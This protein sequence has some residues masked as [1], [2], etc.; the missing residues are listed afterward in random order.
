MPAS[1][2]SGTVISPLLIPAVSITDE[3]AYKYRGMHLDVGRHMF[4]VDFI[5]KYID[6][7]ALH[8]MNTFHWHL[9]EDQGWRIEIK[10]YPELTTIGSQRKETIVEK[11]F[12]PYVG[13]GKP[14]GG[15]YTQNEVKDIVAYASKNHITVIPEIEMPG[16]ALAAIAS[17][18]QLGNT[19]KQ[20]EVGTKWGV[21]ENRWR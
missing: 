8:K 13:D 7:M 9:T 20:L 16:H 6:L 2:E 18:P 15:F 11:N 19:G 21:F 14:Y 3:P 17:Y 5:K 12:D 4:P 10:K 1:L